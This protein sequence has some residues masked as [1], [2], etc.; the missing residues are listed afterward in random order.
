MN[1][2]EMC[3]LLQI[4]SQWSYLINLTLTLCVSLT[5]QHHVTNTGCA[6]R[7]LLTGKKLL[8]P[9]MS[10]PKPSDSFDKNKALFP[11]NPHYHR[12]D[13]TQ[14]WELISGANQ[15]SCKPPCTEKKLLLNV[16]K[17]K[18]L[19]GD[20]RTKEAKKHT[21]VSRF[22]ESREQ[23]LMSTSYSQWRA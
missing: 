11:D 4:K 18:E 15:Q 20:F 21:S 14:Q 9:S 8:Y 1:T 2:C 19:I 12:R 3:H 23:W 16:N 10:S 17:T 5:G 22:L 7:V 13:Y 6:C